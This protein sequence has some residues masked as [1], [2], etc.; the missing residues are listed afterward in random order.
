MPS[1]TTNPDDAKKLSDDVREA[2]NRSSNGSG[3]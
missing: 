3:R 2:N 1:P